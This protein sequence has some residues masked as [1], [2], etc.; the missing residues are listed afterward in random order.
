MLHRRE[1]HVASGRPAVL[2]VLRVLI[3]SHGKGLLLHVGVNAWSVLA[4]DLIS[5][6]LAGRGNLYTLYA[7]LD[8]LDVALDARVEQRA[9]IGA[10][11][12]TG[13]CTTGAHLHFELIDS[14]NPL[15]WGSASNSATGNLPDYTAWQDPARSVDGWV[16]WIGP[17]P[18]GP[19]ETLLLNDP[20][21]GS[22]L[23]SLNSFWTPFGQDVVL[24]DPVG[25]VSIRQNVTDTYARLESQSLP[26]ASA[27]RV[28]MRHLL[29]SG[30]DTFLPAVHFKLTS[31]QQVSLLWMRSRWSLD[32]CSEP[33]RY[34][35]FFDGVI[36]RIWNGT[37]NECTTSAIAATSI[38]G[39]VVTSEMTV[40][41]KSGVATYDLDGDGSED[42][43]ATFT[44]PQDAKV[45][46]IVLDG[47]GWF[48]G[49]RLDID[50]VQVWYL[51]AD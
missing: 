27:V 5:V 35:S 43:R 47:Y 32:Y 9:R 17:G 40:D 46:R 24:G 33:G 16:P 4:V 7:H 39:R 45:E 11:G 13:S 37:R 29:T 18:G 3:S 41:V 1:E 10:S 42:I 28:R 25:W 34:T 30:S 12:N 8:S 23:A 38:Y 26:A 36:F 19:T 14:A 50:S 22:G 20:F 21:D 2:F 44:A 51:P 15:T 6:A 31:G 48:T 49:H